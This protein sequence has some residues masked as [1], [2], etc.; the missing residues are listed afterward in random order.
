MGISMGMSAHHTWGFAMSK[1]A[2]TSI[3]ATKQI[4]KAILST[5]ERVDRSCIRIYPRNAGLY[6][7]LTPCRQWRGDS[8]CSHDS[9]PSFTGFTC[10]TITAR[11]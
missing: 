2:A 1:L 6:M 5:H 11:K 8:S 10:T 3:A 7:I 4:R 9:R